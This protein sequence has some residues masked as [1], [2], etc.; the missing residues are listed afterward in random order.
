M[1]YG[2]KLRAKIEILLFRHI[3]LNHYLTFHYRFICFILLALQC[4]ILNIS[5]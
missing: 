4:K 1:K 5:I 2:V 3:F